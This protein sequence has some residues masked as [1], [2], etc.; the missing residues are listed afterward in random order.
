M[1]TDKGL[2]DFKGKPMVKYAIDLLSGIFETVVISANNPAYEQFGLN[3]IADIHKNCGPIGGLHAAL[4]ASNTD[5]IFALSCDMPFVK[6]EHIVQLVSS[7]NN[8][9]IVVPKTDG[10]LQPLCAIYSKQVLDLLAQNIEKKQL[11]MHQLILD[12]DAKI[13]VPMEASAFLNFN[14]PSDFDKHR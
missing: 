12:T 14:S 2:I 10:Y 3:V 13:T 9:L 6:N 11:K 1:G 4:F 8:E 7:L 5:Y